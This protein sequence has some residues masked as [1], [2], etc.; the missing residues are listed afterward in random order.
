MLYLIGLG[1]STI[2]DISVSGLNIIKQCDHVF[3]DSYTSVLTH[4]VEKASEFL[5]KE[6]KCAD[7]EFTE[8]SSLMLSLAEKNKVAFLVVGDPLCATTHTGELAIN[9]YKFLRSNNPCNQ[10]RDS[11]SHC[12]QCWN[13]D[14]C[15][16]LW[17]STLSHG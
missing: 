14:S 12:S 16:L 13:N 8:Q 4:G 5:G 9:N 3:I 7:R 2:E 10:G 1:L 15:S 11:V 6:V 17:Y